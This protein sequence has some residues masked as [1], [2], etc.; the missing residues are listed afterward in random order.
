MSTKTG[1]KLLY[2]DITYKI[3]GACFEVWR[4]FGGAF[5]EKIVDRALS[6]AL[7]KRGLESKKD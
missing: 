3:R 1:E 6:K 7:E 2:E 4:E 5:K